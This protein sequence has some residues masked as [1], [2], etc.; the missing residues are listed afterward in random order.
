M[1]KKN[2]NTKKIWKKITKK[3]YIKKKCLL[4]SNKYKKDKNNI[5]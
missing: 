5:K 3:N 1:A 2:E 4:S